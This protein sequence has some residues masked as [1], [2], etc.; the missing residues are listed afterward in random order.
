VVV[1]C[2]LYTNVRRL[3]WC[4]LAMHSSIYTAQRES[5]KVNTSDNPMFCRSKKQV[6]G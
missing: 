3:N 2:I 6:R 5:E 1:T 4:Q